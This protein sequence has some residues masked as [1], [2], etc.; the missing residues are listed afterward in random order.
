FFSGG[1]E[2]FFGSTRSGT[3]S[4]TG[5][6]TR[7]GS[8]AGSGGTSASATSGVVITGG[9]E[10]MKWKSKSPATNIRTNTPKNA[11]ALEG[12]GASSSSGSKTGGGCGAA[13]REDDR[14]G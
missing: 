6:G 11:R 5:S 10:P 8:G 9:S 1:G 14:A 13:G 3:R 7:T 2:S 12:R 4:G